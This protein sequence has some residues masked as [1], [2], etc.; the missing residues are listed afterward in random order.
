MEF[1]ENFVSAGQSETAGRHGNGIKRNYKKQVDRG[2]FPRIYL[3]LADFGMHTAA[4]PSD[5]PGCR[6]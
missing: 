1:Q 4:N 5:T 2:V 6:K 3:F